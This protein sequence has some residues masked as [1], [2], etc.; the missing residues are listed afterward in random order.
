MRRAA[1]CVDVDAADLPDGEVLGHQVPAD[2]RR[3]R[4][5]DVPQLVE[6][7]GEEVHP[8]VALAWM[9][10]DQ[11]KPAASGSIVTGATGGLSDL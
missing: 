5:Q 1:S 3:G 7:H 10:I 8:R 6:H 9:R 2:P 11:P 4:A